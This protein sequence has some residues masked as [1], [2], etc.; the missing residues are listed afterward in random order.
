MQELAFIAGI[1]MGG[2]LYRLIIEPARRKAYQVKLS[3]LETKVEENAVLQNDLRKVH[4]D[5]EQHL[6]RVM[7][8]QTDLTAKLAEYEEICRAT[9][10]LGEYWPDE[11]VYIL[12]DTK[13]KS[14]RGVTR[15]KERF[16]VSVE[17]VPVKTATGT[18]STSGYDARGGNNLQP[19]N[20]G[21]GGSRGGCPD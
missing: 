13:S 15:S 20:G 19:S 7:Q 2:I 5:A 21:K 11:A 9:K 1:V 17:D 6:N 14:G 3:I 12:Y 18:A 16:A 4:G 8:L 10:I